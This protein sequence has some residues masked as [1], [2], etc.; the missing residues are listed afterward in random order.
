[1]NELEEK[2]RQSKA[3][4]IL[5]NYLQDNN[6]LE[7]VIKHLTISKENGE[8][9]NK[10]SFYQDKNGKLLSNYE[11]NLNDLD[12][13]KLEKMIIYRYEEL[14]KL[15]FDNNLVEEKKIL[16]NTPSKSYNQIKRTYQP[17]KSDEQ[18]MLQ[19]LHNLINEYPCLLIE[20]ILY[21]NI[22]IDELIK[23]DNKKLVLN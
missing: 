9:I 13:S 18:L 16:N 3:I 10:L 22:S 20:I 23:S 17:L 14:S 12:K 6:L 7:D 5:L 21:Y 1:M 15:Y 8:V 19:Q 11:V 2:I 4:D